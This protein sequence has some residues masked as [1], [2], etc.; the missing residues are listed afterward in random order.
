MAEWGTQS[1]D[2]NEGL[3][4]A[5]VVPTEESGAFTST[6][7]GTVYLTQRGCGFGII[8]MLWQ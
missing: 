8:K 1:F 7:P 2:P 5:P 6:T 4:V 3:R